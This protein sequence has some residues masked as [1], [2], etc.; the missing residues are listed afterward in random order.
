MVL[1][2]VNT[3]DLPLKP[4]ESPQHLL[5]GS[6]A[7]IKRR[8]MQPYHKPAFLYNIKY[9]KTAAKTAT[10]I[11]A[12]T[13]LIKCTPE[14]TRTIA[15][16]KDTNKKITPNQLQGDINKNVKG[17]GKGFFAKRF[18]PRVVSSLEE[19][20]LNPFDDDRKKE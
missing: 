7:I 4:T 3:A 1:R 16:A 13:S 15:R 10:T 12:I 14:T 2:R 11:P 19:L 9:P 6:M 18:I 8:S 5:F 20:D 17:R